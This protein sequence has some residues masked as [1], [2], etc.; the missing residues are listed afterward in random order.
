M[1]LET[2]MASTPIFGQYAL[3]LDRFFLGKKD[4]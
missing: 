2:L 4:E 3:K 1:L